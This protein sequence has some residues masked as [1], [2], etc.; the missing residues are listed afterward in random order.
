MKLLSFGC[1]NY[2]AFREETRLELRPLTLLFGKNN[3]GKSA[4]LR[5][6]RLLLRAISTRARGGFPI[7]VDGLGFGGNFREMLHGANPHG[8]ASFGVELEIEGQRL[9]LSATVQNMRSF[10]SG[11]GQ[12]REYNVVSRFQLAEPDITLDWEPSAERIA[13]YKGIGK[14]PFR[15]L[16]PDKKGAPEG[17]NRWSFVEEWRERVQFIEDHLIHLGPVRK[18]VDRLYEAGG[19]RPLG[20]D[21][22]GAVGWLSEDDELLRKTTEWFREH[23]DGWELSL[24]YSG[25]AFRCLLNRGNVSVNLADTGHGMQ[26]VLPVVVQQ[27]AHQTGKEEEFIDLVEQPELHLHA[28]AQAPLG[29]IFLESAKLGNGQLLVETHSENLLL[30]VRRRVAAGVDPE[31]VAIYF[32]EEKPGGHSSVRPIRILS[33]G[34]VDWWPEGVFSE[35]YEE[36]KALRRAARRKS[37]GIHKR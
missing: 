23:L 13:S 17:R 6:P 27:L 36:V 3:S 33:D 24:D 9:Q 32:V 8:A 1:S 26:Q 25:S 29:D 35:G 18:D 7:E 15:G 12:T 34:S 19:L 2:K 22:N 11:H 30:R 14:L 10:E 31:L 16:L 37:K 5:L 28:A 21:G 20:F 4:L